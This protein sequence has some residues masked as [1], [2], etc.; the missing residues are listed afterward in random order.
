MTR[1]GKVTYWI[2]RAIF[3]LIVV[4]LMVTMVL[5][6]GWW[7]FALAMAIR[8]ANVMD[9]AFD[10]TFAEFERK[11]ALKRKFADYLKNAGKVNEA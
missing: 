9:V 6:F 3:N 8:M 10:K 7:A 11:R 4:A 5:K 1:E 2:I